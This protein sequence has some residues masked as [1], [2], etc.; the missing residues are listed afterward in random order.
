MLY[1]FL[2]VLTMFIVPMLLIAYSAGFVAAIF[3]IIR[4]HKKPQ[5]EPY[6]TWLPDDHKHN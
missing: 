4:L 1:L 2:L 5:K 6:N 3:D